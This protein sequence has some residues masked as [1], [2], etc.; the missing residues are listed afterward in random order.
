[1][2]EESDVCTV[3]MPH[4][5]AVAFLEGLNTSKPGI[6]MSC[7]EIRLDSAAPLETVRVLAAGA[8]SAR[9]LEVPRRAK[10]AL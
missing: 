4:P 10:E 1:M 9:D 3:V 6:L 5:P 2:V 8:V 7:F